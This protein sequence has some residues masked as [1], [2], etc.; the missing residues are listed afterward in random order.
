MIFSFG[1]DK[2][3]IDVPDALFNQLDLTNDPYDNGVSGLK[4]FNVVH[5]ALLLSALVLLFK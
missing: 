3:Y 1:I 5:I 2:V 4:K